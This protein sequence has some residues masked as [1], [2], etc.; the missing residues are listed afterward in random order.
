MA[1]PA[2]SSREAAAPPR[3]GS[4]PLPPAAE[5]VLGANTFVNL[6]PDQA[7]RAFGR[8]AG[9]L[10]R[11]PTVLTSELLLWASDE[12]RVIAGASPIT[13][14]P[15]D[16]RFAD[17]AWDGPIWGRVAQSYLA[18]RASLLRSV[19]E[20]GLDPKSAARARFALTQLAD[21]LAP[22]NA[23][24]GNPAAMKKAWRTRGRSLADGARHMVHDLRRNGGMP[25]QVDSRPFRVGET[26]AV[27]PG[28]V[29]YRSEVFELLQ[30]QPQTRLVATIPTVVVPPQINRYYFIDLAPGRS[31]VEYGVSRGLPMYMIS[32]RNPRPEHRHWNL[33]TYAEACLEAVRVATEISKADQANLMGFCSGGMTEAALLSHLAQTGDSTINAGGMAVSLV[34]TEATSD[35]NVFMS[36]ETMRTS[37]A[38]S[39]RRGV[40]DGR[41]LSRVFSW[42]RP[43]DLVWNYWVA[44]YLMGE[45]PP[46]FDVLAW[47]ADATNMSAALHADFLQI[48]QDNALVGRGRMDL[49]G[50]P[51]DLSQVKNDMY[52][53]GAQSD[54]L[55]PWPSAY[56]ATQVFGG[57]VRFVLSRSGHI[58]SLV[59]P[60]GNPKASYYL[61][62]ANPPGSEE[63]LRGA[64]SLAGS[65]WTDWADWAVERSGPTR[66]SP[67]SMGSRRH[68]AIGPAPGQYVHES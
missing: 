25:S 37:L 2:E 46:A 20:L 31:F 33:D 22:T 9:S 6:S 39:Q 53:V 14:D 32:W 11:H 55:V 26:I 44:N 35:L 4:D 62:P 61:N 30:Y 15:K 23:L 17:P 45:N 16:K 1:D 24:A 10:L 54:H 58:Q 28:S 59:N 36:E 34:D 12:L 3:P 50:T 38:R 43:N 47:N 19:D 8:W 60:P 68:P 21:A 56:A 63:W 5:S 7:G 41:S 67:K 65:W 66:P 52:V 29:V 18:S 40:L 13:P 48:W 27:T 49:L 51:V 64:G 42:M 57:D